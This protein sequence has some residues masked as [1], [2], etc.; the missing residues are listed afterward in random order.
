VIIIDI[1]FAF[2]AVAGLPWL[3][4]A[5][6]ASARYVILRLQ[7]ARCGSAFWRGGRHRLPNMW[8]QC[9]ERRHRLPRPL[10]AIV[11]AS[12]ARLFA[13]AAPRAHKSTRRKWRPSIKLVAFAI[14]VVIAS[15]AAWAWQ[16]VDAPITTD[17]RDRDKSHSA[18]PYRRSLTQSF[19]CSYD[20]PL[21]VSRP[22]GCL[23]SASVIGHSMPLDEATP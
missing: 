2:G 5:T 16:G 22:M 18:R 14:P 20:D 4:E 3:I 13:Y 1:V 6:E 19:Q 15:H 7:V 10:R 21:Q 9:D 8:G 12:L 17:G 23:D 11:M